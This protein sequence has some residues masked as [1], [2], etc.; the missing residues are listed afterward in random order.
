[1]DWFVVFSP[2]D[3]RLAAAHP[4]FRKARCRRNLAIDLTRAKTQN[5]S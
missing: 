5:K 2:A 1:M 4:S 3:F